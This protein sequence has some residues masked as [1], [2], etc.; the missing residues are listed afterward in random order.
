MVRE[1]AGQTGGAVSIGNT[2]SGAGAPG[3]DEC[4]RPSASY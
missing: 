4:V 2:T 1:Y 3:T